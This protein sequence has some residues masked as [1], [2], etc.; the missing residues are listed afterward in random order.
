MEFYRNTHEMLKPS[1]LRYSIKSLIPLDIP[2]WKTNTGQKKLS[3]LGQ[4]YG[5]K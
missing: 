1:F 2:L 4:K 5:K 3:L